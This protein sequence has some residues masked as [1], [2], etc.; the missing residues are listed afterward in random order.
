MQKVTLEHF[1]RAAD[2]IGSHGDND[3]LPFDIDNRFISDKKNQLARV[4]FGFFS[5]L[6]KGGAEN[7]K[8]KVNSLNIFTER[9]LSPTGSSGFRISTKIHPFWNI[10]LNGLAIAIAEENEKNRSEF[11]HSYRFVTNGENIFDREKSWR[12]YKEATINNPSLANED[13]YVV[14]TDISSFYEHIYHHRIENCIADLFEN[15][16]TV[17]IQMDRLLSKISSGRSFGLP[18]GGQCSRI[19]AELLMTSIDQLLTQSDVVWHRYVDDFTLI[20]SSQAE[21][22]RSLSILSNALAD[23]G[24]SLNRSKTTILKSQHYE[25][26]VHAQL[27]SNEDGASKL[28]EIDLHFDP[29]SDNPHED[30][31]NLVD[32]VN[33]LDVQNLLGLEIHKSQPDAFLI[34]QISRTLKLHEPHVALNLCQTLLSPSNLHS[35]RGSWSTIIRGVGSLRNAEKYESIFHQIDH[36]IDN[37]ICSSDHLLL[38]EANC[39]HFLRII[40]HK[41]TDI[42]SKYVYKTV[43]EKTNSNTL[44]RA[45]IDCMRHWKD[46]PSFVQIRNQWSNLS[47][48]V[49]RM[50]WLSSYQFGDDGLHFRNQVKS[51]IEHLWKLGFEKQGVTSFESLYTD[52]VEKNAIL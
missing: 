34:A 1:I 48:E 32:T 15:E 22:Y 20:A 33:Q 29:Y 27:F 43:F 35:F 12:A 37:I 11:A 50:F 26:F 10:Y 36:L 24:L 49:Q 44:K 46:R 42:R 17:A 40:R 21:A 8:N 5:G 45:C 19:L 23:Y 51:S 2:D 30:Y 28:K 52:W 16:S 47:T 31:E 6:E 18:V 14:Q 41:K 4:A 3:M 25:N 38:P 13:A 7:T 39:L 9:L